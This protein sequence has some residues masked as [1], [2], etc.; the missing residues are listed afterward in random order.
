MRV[1]LYDTLSARYLQSP[2]QWTQDAN[3]AYDLGGTVEAVRVAFQKKLECAE[4]I[5]AF[6]DEHLSDMRLPL[7]LAR[8]LVQ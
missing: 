5:L 8:Q 1:L 4:I 2:E 3:L 6:D 7:S